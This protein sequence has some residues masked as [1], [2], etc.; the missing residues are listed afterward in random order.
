MKWFWNIWW[1]QWTWPIKLVSAVVLLALLL[2]PLLLMRGCS[3]PPKLNEQEI[4]KGEQAV[5]ANNDA[6]LKEVLVESDVRVATVDANVAYAEN[7]AINARAESREK[8]D[9]ANRD[10]LQA[11]FNNRK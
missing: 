7:V 2:L 8:W 1:N 9:N 6:A 4:Q 10:E 3:K 11:E 5:K